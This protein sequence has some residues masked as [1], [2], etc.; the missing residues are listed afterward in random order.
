MWGFPLVW[1]CLK[2]NAN[3]GDTC[4][5]FFCPCLSAYVLFVLICMKISRPDLNLVGLSKWPG[6]CGCG[7]R[8]EWGKEDFNSVYERRRRRST[9][10]HSSSSPPMTTTLLPLRKR[11]SIKTPKRP[12][13]W[14]GFHKS[15]RFK[16]SRKYYVLHSIIFKVL[17]TWTWCTCVKWQL[18]LSGEHKDVN[19]RCLWTC[20]AEKK[21][22]GCSSCFL[23]ESLKNRCRSFLLSLCGP[24]QL[25]DNLVLGLPANEINFHFLRYLSIQT[26]ILQPPSYH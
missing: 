12:V 5:G 2:S 24:S 14:K 7:A 8:R 22:R 23:A 13:R 1:G 21:I 17:L 3:R 10:I 26:C 25:E 15:S 4:T 20:V 9:S 11:L 6:G 16:P 19:N 18:Q